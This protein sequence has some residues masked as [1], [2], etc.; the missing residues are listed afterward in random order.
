MGM[1]T[2]IS[3][4]NLTPFFDVLV[5]DKSMILS[6]KNRPQAN[7]SGANLPLWIFD[8]ETEQVVWSDAARADTSL[9]AHHFL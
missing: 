5:T 9:H 3:A 8:G 6:N 7:A 2:V 1:I 4:D